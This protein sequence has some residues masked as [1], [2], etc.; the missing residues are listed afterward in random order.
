MSDEKTVNITGY[1][2]DEI[3]KAVNEYGKLESQNNLDENK[4]DK[5]SPK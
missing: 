1:S 5:M 3:K 4:K 2:R